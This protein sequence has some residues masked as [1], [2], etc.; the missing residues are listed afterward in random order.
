MGCIKRN[1]GGLSSFNGG[2]LGAFKNK[3]RKYSS[4]NITISHFAKR[5]IAL[6]N[7]I[8]II[9]ETFV[10]VVDDGFLNVSSYKFLN[11]ILENQTKVGSF[12]LNNEWRNKHDRVKTKMLDEFE[13]FADQVEEV[14]FNLPGGAQTTTIIPDTANTSVTEQG[15]STQSLLDQVAALS[16]QANNGQ[17][18]SNNLLTNS[19]ETTNQNVLSALLSTFQN[20]FNNQML[21]INSS[22][23]QNSKNVDSRLKS[24]AKLLDSSQAVKNYYLEVEKLINVKLKNENHLNLLQNYLK[25]SRTPPSLNHDRFPRCKFNSSKNADNFDE[26]NIIVEDCQKALLELNIRELKRMIDKNEGDIISFKALISDFDDE[27]NKKLAEIDSRAN[28]VNESLFV[29][30]NEHYNR[31]IKE[32]VVKFPIVKPKKTNNNT[33]TKNNNK[34]IK[35]SSKIS[36]S[37]ISGHTNKLHDRPD[38]SS[39][40][41]KVPRNT[42]QQHTSRYSSKV[43]SRSYNNRR[44]SDSHYK[45]FNDSKISRDSNGN[46]NNSTRNNSR[47]FSSDRFQQQKN[48]YTKSSNT[49]NNRQTSINTNSN[50]STTFPSGIINSNMASVRFNQ[51]QRNFSSNGRNCDQQVFRSR[52]NSAARN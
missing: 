3:E 37:D 9:S 23:A 49:T 41:N 20:I 11:I 33:K 31:I 34:K 38:S 24:L 8:E 39:H 18:L 10:H 36:H 30:T 6:D 48:F 7:F 1:N 45:N 27:V 47:T 17:S 12:D 13:N 51:Q 40:K 42:N 35:P 50:S 16:S 46:Q 21:L 19:N 44:R 5:E 43:N 15:H 25:A 14:N 28:K 32:P 29:N 26:Y 22:I 52:R 4:Y 2:Q